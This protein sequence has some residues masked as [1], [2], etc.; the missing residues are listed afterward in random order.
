MVAKSLEGPS[1]RVWRKDGVDFAIRQ[2]SL[3][4]QQYYD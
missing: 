1:R 2:K 4:S 3:L